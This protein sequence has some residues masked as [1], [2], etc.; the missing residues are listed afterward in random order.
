MPDRPGIKLGDAAIMTLEQAADA[1]RKL[2][3][4]TDETVVGTRRTFGDVLSAYV[5]SAGKTKGQ[6]AMN[7]IRQH[8]KLCAPLLGLVVSETPRPPEQV[9]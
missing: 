4:D 1:V 8:E 2:A 6:A 7:T 9:A 5:A 3:V